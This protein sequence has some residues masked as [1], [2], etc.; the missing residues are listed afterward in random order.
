MAINLGDINFGL[1]ADTNRL[2]NAIRDVRAFGREVNQA[3]RSQADGARQ[4]EAA[5][6][7]Q[8]Q[9]LISAYNRTVQLND[10]I[11]QSGANNGLIQTTTNTYNRLVRELGDGRVSALQ[12][13]RSMEDFNTST[14]RVNRALNAH[15]D[16]V[17]QTAAAERDA[18][19]QARA[20]EQAIIRQE[21]AL[22]QAQLAVQRLT[23]QQQRAGAPS[24]IATRATT[25]LSGLQ[26]AIGGSPLMNPVAQQRALQ[27]FQQQMALA[28]NEMSA[29]VRS[30]EGMSRIQSLL[31]QMS[32]AAVLLA[33][34][35]SGIATRL[36]VIAGVTEHFNLATAGFITGVAGATYAMYKLSAATIEVAKRLQQ[37]QQTLFAVFADKTIADTQ[38]KYLMDLAN[39][40]GVEFQSLAKQYGQIEAAAKGTNLEGERTRKIF[41]AIVF[42]GAKLGLST[43]DV[44]GT[45]RAIQQIMSKGSIQLEEMQGQLGD[46]L[47]AAVKILA[48]AL[49]VTELKLR[50]MTKAGELGRSK[51]V[52][53]AETLVKRYNIDTSQ[54]IDTIVAAENRLSNARVLALD[55]LDKNLGISTAYVRI[56][57]AMRDGVLWV[58]DNMGSLFKVLGAVGGAI[59]GMA[60]PTL[61]TALWSAG[62]ATIAFTGAMIGL[63]AAMLANPAG[64][65][66]GVLARLALVVG[67]AGLGMLSMEQ[68]LGDQ[69][70]SYL[71]TLPAVDQYIKS[72]ESLKSSV[73]STTNEY[74]KMAEAQGNL[75]LDRLVALTKE[76]QE[77]SSK[78]GDVS[79]LQKQFDTINAKYL[80]TVKQLT[81]LRD[82]LKRQ[83]DEEN[84]D[85]KDPLKDLT[86]RQ[87]V[88]IKNANDTIRE[89]Q[90]QYDLLYK[91]PAQKDYLKTQLDINKAVENF[92]DT[93][94]RTLGDSPQGKGQIDGLVT[95][96]AA[97]LK[98]VKEGELDLTRHTSYFQAIEGV[99]SRGLDDALGKFVDNIAEGKKAFEDFG[100]VSQAILKD[101]LKSFLQLAAINPLKN[102]LFGTNYTV[103]GGNAGIGGWVGNLIGGLGFA[104]GGIMTSAGPLPIRKY[105]GGGIA[106][107]PQMSIFAENS[108]PEAYVPVPSGKIPVELRSQGGSSSGGVEVHIHDYVGVSAQTQKTTNKSGQP[109]L[110]ILLKRVSVQAAADDIA[111]GGPFSA[112]LERQY[113]LDRTKGMGR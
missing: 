52:E 9:A 90:Q 42:A 13:Q 39:R 89:L 96:Y 82:I 8:E 18:E 78:G 84:R 58:A 5:L 21:R 4:Q 99:F 44:E 102:A 97:A 87:Q 106:R 30:G 109:R 28:R 54:N 17:R 91:A 24:T 38:L 110:D 19:Q 46:R 86:T 20:Y 43:Q 14:T 3:A 59:V 2:Q 49:G 98:K 26:G 23:A 11:R 64:A 40:A 45:L 74:I 50:A 73:R 29:F 47:P 85:R 71:D 67:G 31:Q 66:A 108:V 6:R 33:G 111:S 10:A 63:N 77:V 15:R 92:R 105:A 41:E 100:N 76:I 56:L 62:Q 16:A 75:Q 72:Q 25:A 32:A 37:V 60:M 68:L 94:T 51:L 103:L 22:T 70:R 88:A 69:K 53:F 12:F 7:R 93:L 112:L 79:G 36:S 81:S 35:L 113:G 57:N 61:V 1:G 27:Q 48:D 80:G 101:L 104:G 83:T 55:V 65:L 107:S 95:R 34:P